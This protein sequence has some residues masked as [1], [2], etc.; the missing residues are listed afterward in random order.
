MARVD[1]S[2]LGKEFSVQCNDGEEARVRE[3][4]RYADQRLQTLSR[5]LDGATDL[6]VLMFGCLMLADEI[7]ELRDGKGAKG[8]NSDGESTL[9]AAVDELTSRLERLATRL[10]A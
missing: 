3:L 10:S 5:S 6:R 4:A 1:L 7:F 2:L 9:V 8:N